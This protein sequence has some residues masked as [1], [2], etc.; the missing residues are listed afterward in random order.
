M[1][2][3]NHAMLVS[4]NVRKPQMTMKDAKATRDAERANDAHNAGQFRKDLYPRQLIQ[5]ILTV[6]SSA[7]AYIESTTYVW[8]RGEYLLAN[9][10]FMEFADRMAKYELEFSQ[11]VTAFLNNWNN[12]MSRARDS[13]G[14]LF[15]PSVYPDLD[16]LKAGFKMKVIYRPVTDSSDFRV[17]LQEDELERLRTQVEIEVKDS[18]ESLYRDPLERLRKVVARL[19]EVAAKEDRVSVDKRGVEIIKPPIFRDS[20]I[21]NIH[22]EIDMLMELADVLPERTVKLAERIGE[23]IPSPQKLRDDPD[24]RTDVSNASKHLLKA[25]DMMLEE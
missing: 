12:V 6:E 20:I 22:Q 23:F 15:D 7:R 24:V 19:G 2:I 1:S 9:V 4:L 8:A 16:E 18:M 17:Q 11:C 3:K 25:I 13:H 21:E 5:P 14:D 10:R